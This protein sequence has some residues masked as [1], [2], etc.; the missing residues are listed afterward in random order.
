MGKQHA[1]TV[2]TTTAN[3]TRNILHETDMNTH[4]HSDCSV[5]AQPNTTITNNNNTNNQCEFRKYKIVQKLKM[6][7]TCRYQII[8]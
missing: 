3:S 1:S 6:K 5:H 8:N 7:K 4:I 2:V